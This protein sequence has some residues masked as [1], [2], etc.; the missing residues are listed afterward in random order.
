MSKHTPIYILLIILLLVS[1]VSATDY[2]VIPY[3]A[4]PGAYFIDSGRAYFDSNTHPTGI[5][6]DDYKTV[7]VNG[8]PSIPTLV[9]D[10]DNDGVNEIVLA[11]GNYIDAYEKTPSTLERQARYTFTDQIVYIQYANWSG[12]EKMELIVMT[13]LGGGGV[14]FDGML[15]NM[16]LI[17][18]TDWAINVT[19]INFSSLSEGVHAFRCL[20]EP[21]GAWACFKP[22]LSPTDRGHFYV[23]RADDTF[24]HTVVASA[25]GNRNC[26]T[27]D[28]AIL[29]LDYDSD[30][31]SEYLYTNIYYNGATSYLQLIATNGTSSLQVLAPNIGAPPTGYPGWTGDT[32]RAQN[33]H[34]KSY[35]PIEYTGTSSDGIEM[36]VTFESNNAIGSGKNYLYIYSTLLG[37]NLATSDLIGDEIDGT[38]A[39]G[40]S[41]IVTGNFFPYANP[42][43]TAGVMA[44]FNVSGTL[45]LTFISLT[46]DYNV[47]QC[48]FIGSEEMQGSLEIDSVDNLDSSFF[49]QGIETTGGSMTELLTPF[50]IYTPDFICQDALALFDEIIDFSDTPL[51]DYVFR[52]VDYDEIGK[53]DLLGVSPSSLMYI[54]DSYSNTPAYLIADSGELDPCVSRVWLTNTSVLVSFTVGDA[55]SDNVQARVILYEGEAFEQDSGWVGNHSSPNIFSFVDGVANHTGSNYALS[56]YFQ[57][58]SGNSANSES[59]LF[60]VSDVGTGEAGGSCVTVFGGGVDAV[61][62]GAEAEDDAFVSLEDAQVQIKTTLFGTLGISSGYA[63]LFAILI[64]IVSAIA[65]IITILQHGGNDVS[66]IGAGVI[67]SFSLWVFFIW[68]EFIP[69]WTMLVFLMM[70]VLIIG[71]FF[72]KRV[73]GGG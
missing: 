57:D 1:I 49:I 64:I 15:Y 43:V 46:E 62:G 61:V 36:A 23:N 30:G 40:I 44:W 4:Y 69:P 22:S 2:S 38:G 29:Y 21:D 16:T 9:Y 8:Y 34:V 11:N 10:F 72:G 63:P 25:G 70:S 59:Y 54:D 53:Y 39:E 60:S 52:G 68:L 47:W 19:G 31:T 37:T 26:G 58:D 33:T 32:C 55:E 73:T 48:G 51:N 14:N 45:H 24:I 56:I 71:L 6:P 28:D 12:S 5:T 3:P 67:T 27:D 41:N 18:D 35:I 17:N 13:D 66:S 50:G 42:S 7:N 65:V 20:Q